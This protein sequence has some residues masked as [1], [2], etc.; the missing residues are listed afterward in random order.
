ML[1]LK[2]LDFLE[3]SEN[4]SFRPGRSTSD[5]P[6]KWLVGSP[7]ADLI[8]PKSFRPSTGHANLT[9]IYSGIAAGKRARKQKKNTGILDLSTGAY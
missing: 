4:W 3:V 9:W 2:R 6:D 5:F 7:I 8:D 1:L